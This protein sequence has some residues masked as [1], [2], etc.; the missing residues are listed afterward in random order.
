[1]QKLFKAGFIV[2]VLSLLLL[3]N[4]PARADA[5]AST[6]NSFR[7]AGESGRFF[8]TAYGYAVFPTIG[9]IG[10]MVGGAHGEGRV[11]VGGQHVGN[12]SMTQLTVGFQMGAQAFS[13]I[14]FF[15]NQAA[16]EQFTTGNFE[17][18][19]QTSA[20][21]VTAGVSADA[22]TAGGLAAGASA[23]RNDATTAH[24]G[25]RKGLAVFTLARG[26]LMVEAA[27]G[28][29]KFSFSPLQAYPAPAPLPAAAPAPGVAPAPAPGYPVQVR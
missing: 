19:A 3:A 27:V 15:Q 24:S 28:G 14:I 18:S 20:V 12:T 10:F 26:G 11:F 17:F 8:D 13:Q 2:S 9:R 21:A 23:G 5:Y 22:S 1:M 4:A 25:Y 7:N 6:I 29:Q 16:F